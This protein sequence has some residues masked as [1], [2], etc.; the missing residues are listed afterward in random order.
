MDDVLNKAAAYKKNDA[1]SLYTAL[2]RLFHTL[3]VST[4]FAL[5]V[6][7]LLLFQQYQSDWLT[8]QTRYSGESIARQYAKLLQPAFIAED[9]AN[10]ASLVGA[11][12]NQRDYI[13]AVASVLVDEPHI[14]AL[15]VFDK[16]GRYIAPLPKINSVVELSQSQRVTPLTYIGMITDKEGNLLGYVNIHID[17]QAVLE[18]PL[19]L[20]YQLALIAGILVFLALL[21]GVYLT[22]AFY[23]SRPWFIQVIES[24]KKHVKIRE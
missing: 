5:I 4:V 1:H 13:E 8:V 11:S 23:K 6:V 7:L 20:R 10:S 3:I 17:T 16:D 12:Q 2:K 21:L 18:S 19:T 22:R 15:A 14:L 24:K 9:L